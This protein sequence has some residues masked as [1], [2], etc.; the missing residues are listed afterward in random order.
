MVVANNVYFS[1]ITHVPLQNEQERLH[2]PDVWKVIDARVAEYEEF[3]P[4]LTIIFG[5]DHYSNI[6]LELAPTFLVGHKAKSPGIDYGGISGDLNVPIERSTD[7]ARNLVADGFDIANSYDMNVDHGF[8]VVLGHFLKKELGARPV[9]PVHINAMSD[10]LPSLLR[11]REFGA[12]VGSWA[13]GLGKRVAFLGSAG[14][15]HQ[16]DFVFPQY[17]TAPDEKFQEL[18]VH[19]PSDASMTEVEWHGSIERAM[20][21][22]SSEIID[23]SFVAPW[24]NAEWD[25]NFLGLLENGDLTVFDEWTD[26]YIRSNAGFGAGEIRLFV[27]AAAA[28][29]SAGMNNISVDLYS[30]RTTFGTGFGVVHGLAL[31]D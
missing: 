7:L 11:C 16:T 12:A 28:A 6:F 21:K 18:M 2:N 24:I 1:G 22:M 25:T 26:D 15:S 30:D 29:Q 9:I 20:D 5:C 3:D 31:P 19:G 17:A 8:T 13:A 10:P 27:A 4:D 14:L 23:G